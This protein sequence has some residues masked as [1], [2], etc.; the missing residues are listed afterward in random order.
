LFKKFSKA[1]NIKAALKLNF[2][3]E[4]KYKS[5]LCENP[6]RKYLIRNI[7]IITKMFKDEGKN[8]LHEQSFTTQKFMN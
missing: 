6:L 7:G 4:K 3:F 1:K 5:F 8:Y 2:F